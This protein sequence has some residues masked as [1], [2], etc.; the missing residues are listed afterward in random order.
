MANFL[1]AMP[2]YSRPSNSTLTHL[3]VLPSPE[4]KRLMV[5]SR[6][7]EGRERGRLVQT[8]GRRESRNYVPPNRNIVPHAHTY[9]SGASHKSSVAHIFFN[10][11]QL[12]DDRPLPESYEGEQPFLGR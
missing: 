9:L 4:N 10:V 1:V 6:Q 3:E 5:F 2:Y 12:D 7:N 8:R 11:T